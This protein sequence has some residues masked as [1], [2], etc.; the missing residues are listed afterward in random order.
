MRALTI[1][2]FTNS[3]F[4]AP[5]RKVGRPKKFKYSILLLQKIQLEDHAKLLWQKIQLED[6]IKTKD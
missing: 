2:H 3:V 6:H 5:V 1:S 4:S